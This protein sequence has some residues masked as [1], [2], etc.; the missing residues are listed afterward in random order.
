MEGEVV[1][2][3][4][5]STLVCRPPGCHKG[6][7]LLDEIVRNRSWVSAQG[8]DD[9]GHQSAMVAAAESEVRTEAVHCGPGASWHRS[10]ELADEVGVAGPD[11][12]EGIAFPAG[13]TTPWVADGGSDRSGYTQRLL[14]EA[15]W[16]GAGKLQL[17]PVGTSK[18]GDPGQRDCYLV[19]GVSQECWGR[20]QAVVCEPYEW[21]A[22]KVTNGEVG[23]VQGTITGVGVG[24]VAREEV[25]VGDRIRAIVPQ[26]RTPWVRVRSRARARARA[27]AGPC[28]RVMG[29]RA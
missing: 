3:K 9:A 7:D 16:R 19:A 11:G 15:A 17:G 22:H 12:P 24:G 6:Q 20:V 27:E 18:E 2:H 28:H 25:G 1:L 14:V 23:E 8:E 13:P 29:C 26:S 10:E 5:G 4:P 21:T